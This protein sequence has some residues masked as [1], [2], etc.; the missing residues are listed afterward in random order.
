MDTRSGWRSTETSVDIALSPVPF[1]SA[2][3]RFWLSGHF[4]AVD[5]NQKQTWTDFE[6]RYRP[7]WISITDATWLRSETWTYQ[8][9]TLCL[10]PHKAPSTSLTSSGK[11]FEPAYI[12][13]LSSPLK[14]VGHDLTWLMRL[15]NWYKLQIWSNVNVKHLYNFNFNSLESFLKHPLNLFSRI[16]L[17]R[18]HRP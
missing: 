11:S 16:Q 4:R 18:L 7:P 17:V 8:W 5:M 13:H 10:S 9:A 12:I 3:S 15:I 6:L 14:H 1:F 2:L